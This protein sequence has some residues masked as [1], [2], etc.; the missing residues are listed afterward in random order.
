MTNKIPTW[1]EFMAPV[2]KVLDSGKDWRYRDLWKEAASQMQLSDDVLA[3][4]MASG[5]SRVENRINWATSHLFHANAVE[6]PSRGVYRINDVGRRVLAAHPD[7]ITLADIEPF[8]DLTDVFW[9]GRSKESPKAGTPTSV[10]LDEDL[11]P[12]EQIEAARQR[13]HEEV[14]SELLRRLQDKD[15]G[16]FENAVVKLL[17][18]MGYGGAEGQG[19]VTPLTNDG[20]VDGVIDRD[21][22]GID[23]VYIQAKRYGPQGSVQRQE[24]QS[25]VGALSGKASSGVFITTARFSKGA[26][27]YANGVPTRIILIDGKRL[28]SLMIRYQV[29]VQVK[30]TVEVVEVD[31]DFFE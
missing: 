12:R 24:V 29:G 23:R 27:E 3:E 9:T 1:D 5:G 26:E 30:E 19:Q 2:L 7:R 10:V 18:A 17:L 22:L 28:T 25:F 21:A 15:P 31:E 6:R 14:A 13:I 16:F 4:T 20:G 11:E 8:A